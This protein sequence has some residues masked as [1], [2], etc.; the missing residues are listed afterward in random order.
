MVEFFKVSKKIWCGI[1]QRIKQ[2]YSWVFS[3]SA[4]RSP[5]WRIKHGIFKEV[6][7]LQTMNFLK[8]SKKW[9]FSKSINVYFLGQTEIQMCFFFR[10]ICSKRDFLKDQQISIHGFFR[11][12]CCWCLIVNF[13][14]GSTSSFCGFFSK[15][16]Q[17][18]KV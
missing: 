10:K 9:F 13:N 5:K 2:L 1:F 6:T 18:S 12:T 11:S 3:K 8:S 16:Q 4:N 15:R 14:E 17:V 7:E